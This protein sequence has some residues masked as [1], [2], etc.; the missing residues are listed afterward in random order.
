MAI[1]F[2]I[3]L[4]MAIWVLYDAKKIGVRKGLV[5]GIGNLSP[6]GWFWLTSILGIIGFGIYWYHRGKLIEAVAAGSSNSAIQD[7]TPIVV[8]SSGQQTKMN[9]LK[10]IGVVL[11]ALVLFAVLQESGMKGIHNKVAEDAV[12]QYEIAARSGTA[13]DVCVQAGFVSAAYLQAQ[14]EPAYK[15]WKNIEQTDCGNAGIHR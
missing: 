7:S 12:K 13:I 10:V 5:S 3:G 1:Q 15:R 9:P 6:W 2:I 4:V 11:G 14:D 8:P